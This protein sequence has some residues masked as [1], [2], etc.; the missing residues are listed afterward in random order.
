[1]K[2]QKR[3]LRQYWHAMKKNKCNYTVLVRAVKC[4]Y[5]TFIAYADS[6]TAALFRVIYSLLGKSGLEKGLL[7][8]CKEFTQHLKDRVSHIFS[9]LNATWL[10]S[11]EMIW[12]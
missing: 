6:H 10:N 9:K 11:C 5:P 7:D 3:C 2:L 1:M 4:D 12:D 8:H